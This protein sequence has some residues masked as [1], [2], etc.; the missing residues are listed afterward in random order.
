MGKSRRDLIAESIADY[1]A[2]DD[3]EQGKMTIRV[4]EDQPVLMGFITNLADEFTEAEH[5]TLVDSAIILINAFVSV[6]IPVEMIPKQL[7]N[8]V[9]EEK[10]KAYEDLEETSE[11][12]LQ[13]LTDSP[14]VF[15]DL[16][17]RAMLKSGLSESG[18]LTQNN[19]SMVL[20]AIITM[21]ERSITAEYNSEEENQ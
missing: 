9:I 14:Q 12:E 21:I 11:S 1:E 10:T 13:N 18:I 20:D 7:V 4:M 19:Y 6:G 5:E 17:H 3:S 2:M 16:R 15:Q 8:E